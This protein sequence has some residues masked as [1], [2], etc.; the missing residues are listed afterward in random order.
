MVKFI[1]KRIDKRVKFAAKDDDGEWWGYEEKPHQGVMGWNSRG[2][3]AM[4]LTP[5][6]VQDVDDDYWADSLTERPEIEIVVNWALLPEKAKCVAMD[7]V[8]DF[9][10]GAKWHWFTS[11]TR[12]GVRTWMSEGV[13][14]DPE[15]RR[16]PPLARKNLLRHLRQ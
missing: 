12:T 14:G 1:W 6:M 5:A 4:S 3:F 13:L 10:T 9:R 16:S 11:D 8:K 15:E 7:S 2:S